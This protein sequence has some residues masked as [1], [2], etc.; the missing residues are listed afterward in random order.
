MSLRYRVVP[1]TGTLGSS[2]CYFKRKVSPSQSEELCSRDGKGAM[3]KARGR[4]FKFQPKR[5]FFVNFGGL[6]YRLMYPVLKA[7][8]FGTTFGVPVQKTGTKGHL[9]LVP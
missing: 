2:M 9:Q 5:I 3:R 4:E 1:P 6:R 7:R 8:A